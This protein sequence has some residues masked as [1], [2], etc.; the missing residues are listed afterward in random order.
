MRSERPSRVGVRLL[1]PGMRALRAAGLAAVASLARPSPASSPSPARAVPRGH[2]G[3]VAALA[4]DRHGGSLASVVAAL[5]FDPRGG[6][7]ASAGADGTIRLWD[8]ST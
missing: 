3:I 7:L 8:V 2:A 6:S 1:T 5:A 4:F